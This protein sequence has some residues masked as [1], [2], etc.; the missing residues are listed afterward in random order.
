MIGGAPAEW[1]AAA[2]PNSASRMSR[3]TDPETEEIDPILGIK[4]KAAGTC[5]KAIREFTPA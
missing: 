5:P 3:F 2:A 4:T 1:S